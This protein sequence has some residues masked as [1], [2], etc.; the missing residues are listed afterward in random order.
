MKITFFKSQ[1]KLRK[2]F[3]KNHDKS[4][5]NY[6]G[7][8]KKD[9]GKNGITYPE[10]LDEALCFGWI[11]GVRKTVDTESY[12]IRFTPRKKG[13]IWSAVNIAKINELMQNGKIHESGLKTYKE[14][15]LKRQKKYSYENKIC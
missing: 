1:S 6:I 7:F 13:S 15:D 4:T 8:Y 10:A 12:M 3:L 2:W 11:D 9:S 14:R 5:E